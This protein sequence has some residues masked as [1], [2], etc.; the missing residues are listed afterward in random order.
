MFLSTVYITTLVAL[1]V[2]RSKLRALRFRIVW[3]DWFN[4]WLEISVLQNFYSD[5]SCTTL[6]EITISPANVCLPEE[7][8]GD[9]YSI[10][11]SL[12]DGNYSSYYWEDS[13][14]CTGTGQTEGYKSTTAVTT[15]MMSIKKGGE[16]NNLVV[17][18]HS[19]QPQR[20]R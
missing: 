18:H 2:N 1:K 15:G 9:V 16:A 5:L 6:E 11:A 3:S 4:C 19:I 17:L 14:N 8:D 7:A 10:K 12:V 20:L 13:S